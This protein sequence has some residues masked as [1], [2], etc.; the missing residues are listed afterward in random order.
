M[1]LIKKDCT[2]LRSCKTFRGQFTVTKNASLCRPRQ[3][4]TEVKDLPRI[5]GLCY[6]KKLRATI[7]L[8]TAFPSANDR[9]TFSAV[10]VPVDIDKKFLRLLLFRWKCR[11]QQNPPPAI[12]TVWPEFYCIKGLMTNMSRDFCN[13]F[14]PRLFCM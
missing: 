14:C 4:R 13:I 9:Y 11:H 12:T 10:L 7:F 6:D 3:S 1:S 2:F 8:H 5:E